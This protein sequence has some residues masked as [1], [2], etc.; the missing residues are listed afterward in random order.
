[1]WTTFPRCAESDYV[2][3]YFRSSGPC[4][5]PKH[6]PPDAPTNESVSSSTDLPEFEPE[7]PPP[8]WW[9]SR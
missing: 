9:K 3:C 2:N 1:M 8:W 7:P 4:Q 5:N 6:K